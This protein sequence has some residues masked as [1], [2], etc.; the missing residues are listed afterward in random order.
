MLA[1]MIYVC[2][3]VDTIA[4]THVPSISLQL[5]DGHSAQ[6]YDPDFE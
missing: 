2:N 6:K 4:G 3:E 1:D 5:R